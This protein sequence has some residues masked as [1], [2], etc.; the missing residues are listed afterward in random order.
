[1]TMDQEKSIS[2][3]L[4]AIDAIRNG[5]MI[6]MVDDE[7]R[8]NEGD[9]VFAAEFVDPA[10]VNFMVREARGLVCL[11]LDPATVDRLKLPLMSSW[12]NASSGRM[13]AFTVSIEARRGVS[14]GISAHDRAET[15]RVAIDPK[16][17]LDDL[18]VPGHVFPLRSKVGGVLERAGHTEGSVDICRLAGL[19]SAAVICEIMND[20]GSMARRADLDV[21]ALRH[22]MELVSIADIIQFRLLRESLVEKISEH[23][24]E[25]SHGAF[26]SVLFRSL[27]DG[28]TQLALV[29]GEFAE[30]AVTQVR[31]HQQRPLVDVFAGRSE[32]PGSRIEYGLSILKESDHAVLLYL[33]HGSLDSSWEGDLVE[34]SSSED[35]GNA[36]TLPAGPRP[37]MDA[38]LFGTGAQILRALGVRKMVVHM[39]TPRAMKGLTGFGLEIVGTKVIP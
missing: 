35:S 22:K 33:Q 18:V 12:P 30:S 36:Q 3:V 14:T 16:S 38:R 24:I 28:S 4:K 26:R 15:I 23:L 17:T 27:M 20:D 5:Q 19:K 32:N 11:T 7:D 31:V 9:L 6:I 10:K 1:M 21:F 25:T 39:T 37:P 29:K 34:M 8:E 13:T 2:R